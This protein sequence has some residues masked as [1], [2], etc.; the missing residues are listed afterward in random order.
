[1]YFVYLVEEPDGS[2]SRVQFQLRKLIGCSSSFPFTSIDSFVMD[3][4]T[5]HLGNFVDVTI[6]RRV[7]GY[8][9]TSSLLATE[10]DTGLQF[11]TLINQVTKQNRRAE[12]NSMVL[13]S[14]Q[15]GQNGIKLHEESVPIRFV[16][17]AQDTLGGIDYKDGFLC[18]TTTTQLLCGEYA[19][20]RLKAVVTVLPEG[21]PALACKAITNAPHTSNITTGVAILS[22]DPL[23]VY[24]GCV[25]DSQP[26][27]LVEWQPGGGAGYAV[28]DENGRVTVKPVLN[29]G[30]PVLASSVFLTHGCNSGND[31]G[32]SGLSIA[33]SILGLLLNLPYWKIPEY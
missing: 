21:S 24:F 23:S 22:V 8:E 10:T 2:N 7:E 20:K 32:K 30:D 28:M 4:C 13:Y 16:G 19:E 29:D 6:D 25:L 5:A 33:L 1:M 9:P 31:V 12:S 18:W 3:E 14:L 26:P 27:R 15:S 17:M 11:F